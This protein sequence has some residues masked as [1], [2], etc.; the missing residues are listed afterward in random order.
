MGGQPAPSLFA[1]PQARLDRR[2]TTRVDVEKY[3]NSIF[4][5]AACSFLP[6]QWPHMSQNR[7]EPTLPDQ[8]MREVHRVAKIG[9]WE[10]TSDNRLLWSD[11]TIQIFGVERAAFRGQM[12][13]FFKLVHP[14]D[15]E[16][17]R[18]VDD[19][20][21]SESAF[22][23]SEY[24]VMRPDGELRHIRQTAS[25]LRDSDGNPHG[26]SGMVQDVSEQVRT[27]AQL[28]QAQKMEAIGQLS[29]GVAHDFN[30]ILAAILG[31]AELMQMEGAYDPDLIESI[32]S[33]AK[34]GGEL[35][36]RL[37]AFARKQ[38]LKTTQVDV[39][40]LI[41]DMAPMLARMVGQDIRFEVNL[42]DDLWLL[43]ADPAPLQ[44]ALLNLAVNA[45][46]AIKGAGTITVYAAN[47]T[48]QTPDGKTRH[49]VEIGMNDTGE[50]M[51]EHVRLQAPI[52]F[53]TTK[54]M[55]KGSGLGLSMV[56]GFVKQSGGQMTINSIPGVGTQVSL[57]MPR[58]QGKA[59]PEPNRADATPR[60]AGERV[61][62]ID[63]NAD[64]ASLVL[65]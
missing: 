53:F 24:R 23:E 21:E 35:T 34:R 44:D 5:S 57:F 1:L 19:F 61:L 27:A 59:P 54:P 49:Y 15:L 58:S 8:L 63:D 30:N 40:A 62:V 25:V 2:T 20:A 11:E 55:K 4:S 50:G 36:H 64:L 52:P 56:D 29:R 46:D 17:V 41:N 65:R 9:T 60:G 38:P 10:L 7:P 28:R 33:S 45:Q 32:V 39:A 51:S 6:M 22:F 43:E 26:F 16:R 18:R 31:A 48:V 37:L 12:E 47:S 14:D 13:E 3:I 42:A